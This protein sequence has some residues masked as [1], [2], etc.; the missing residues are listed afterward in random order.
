MSIVM[1]MDSFWSRVGEDRGLAHELIELYFAERP[2]LFD[3]VRVAALGTDG[4]ALRHAAH[5]LK[6]TIANFSAGPAV[7]TARL[8][9]EM[10]KKDDLGGAAEA[11]ATLG[12]QLV[13]LDSDL[14]E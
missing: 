12:R 4:V 9:E 2:R 6:G 13:L 5:A 10:G 3:D 14:A 11:C 7:D 8:L 1:D